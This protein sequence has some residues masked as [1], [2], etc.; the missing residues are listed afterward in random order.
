MAVTHARPAVV[1]LLILTA[2]G[3]SVPLRA[4]SL[5]DVAKKEEERRKAL[6]VPAKVYTNKDLT[7][8][9]P[10]TPPA[11]SGATASQ[12][13]ADASRSATGA[14]DAD[15]AAKDTEGKGSE[16]K[17][18]AYWAG[19]RKVLQ[20]KLDRDQTFLEALQTRVNSLAADV[21]N[22]DDPAQRA[23][24]ERD[25]LKAVAEL[26]RLQ[27]EILSGKKALADLEE[28]ARRAGVPAG[29]LR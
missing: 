9:P 4:Q 12:S 8:P 19:R 21:V 13:L 29:W 22:R 16:P 10:G 26:G 5:A 17:G 1:L 2:I 24:L 6:P 11:P 27:Q 18:Q 28:E 20:D 7:A 14:T 3:I 25:R 23:L 15:K